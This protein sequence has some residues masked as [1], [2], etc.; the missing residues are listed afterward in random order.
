MHHL[1]KLDKDGKHTYVY[2]CM[3]QRDFELIKSLFQHFQEIETQV[4]SIL[5]ENMDHIV[6]HSLNV[7]GRGQC[8]VAVL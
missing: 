8:K 4:M 3:K 1:F 7:C 6:D 2:E 5:E